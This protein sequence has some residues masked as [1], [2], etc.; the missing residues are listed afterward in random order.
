MTRR[1]ATTRR[2]ALGTALVLTAGVG[3]LGTG[4]ASAAAPSVSCQTTPAA[5]KFKPGLS[6]RAAK[7]KVTLSGNLVN[8]TGKTK[9]TGG[10][11]TGTLKS[12]R[13]IKC[14]NL[15]SGKVASG[16]EVLHYND[17]T[18]STVRV[19]IKVTSNGHFTM[20]GK[21]TKGRFKG[22]KVTAPMT[23]NPVEPTNPGANCG[24]ASP[25]VKITQINFSGTTTV[26]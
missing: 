13:A 22:H 7:Q 3:W 20:N 26:S 16:T 25:A 18:S 5:A 6:S 15:L 1:I 17:K 24:L 21:V 2:V 23:L 14:S 10:T 12:P 8:C 9:I 4:A 11:I 19:T